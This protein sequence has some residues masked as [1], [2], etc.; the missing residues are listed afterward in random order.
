MKCLQNDLAVSTRGRNLAA[1]ICR[2]SGLYPRAA[3]IAGFALIW[4]MTLAVAQ[5]QPALSEKLDALKQRDQELQAA[6]DAQ[7]KS[8]ETEAAL[9]REIEEIGADRRKLNQ[10]LID[11]ATRSRD[12]ETVSYTHL[13]LPTIYTV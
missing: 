9:K 6:R 12:L 3:L 8:G 7:R 1:M 13:T 11:T 2:T 5:D 4:P 10:D